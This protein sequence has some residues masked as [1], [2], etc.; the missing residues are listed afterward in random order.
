MLV[1]HVGGSGLQCGEALPQNPACWVPCDRK[2]ESFRVHRVLRNS[3]EAISFS[4]LSGKGLSC[5]LGFPHCFFVFQTP[6][7][8]ASSQ[9][10]H[11]ALFVLCGIFHF[12]RF[13]LCV[14][15]SVWSGPCLIWSLMC[16]LKAG[17]PMGT[18]MQEGFVE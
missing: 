2:K 13:Y 17:C 18:R 3:H 1:L 4:R 9:C 14:H 10:F 16:L 15:T 5:T 11:D 6:Q 12:V 7:S 8:S